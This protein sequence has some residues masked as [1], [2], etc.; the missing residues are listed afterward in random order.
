MEEQFSE[1]ARKENARLK[2]TDRRPAIRHF[3]AGVE[4]VR[5]SAVSSLS[6]RRVDAVSIIVLT[7]KGH[8]KI[9]RQCVAKIQHLAREGQNAREKV[10]KVPFSPARCS[11]LPK[12]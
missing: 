9:L 6:V 7:P 12:P 4:I 3:P 1:A 5:E 11:D 10:G 8:C 2:K